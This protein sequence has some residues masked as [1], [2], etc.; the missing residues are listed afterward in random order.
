VPAV[1]ESGRDLARHLRLP[2]DGRR[3]HQHDRA[4]R[5]LR[6]KG[7]DRGMTATSGARRRISA[8]SAFEERQRPDAWRRRPASACSGLAWWFSHRHAAGL[9][10]ARAGGRRTDPS[11]RCRGWR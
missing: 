8:R 9:R 3:A 1:G 5:H 10:A 7:R 2:I 4:G 11:M 6:Q